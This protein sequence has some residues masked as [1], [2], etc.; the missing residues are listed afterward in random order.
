MDGGS[1]RAIEQALEMPAGEIERTAAAI[2]EVGLGVVIQ[3]LYLRL[4]PALG[5]TLAGG[6]SKD[7]MV[8]AK[9]RWATAMTAEV[10]ELWARWFRDQKSAWELVCL[11]LRSML[12]CLNHLNRTRSPEQ[13]AQFAADLENLIFLLD[14]PDALVDVGQVRNS[15][16]AKLSWGSERYRLEV[17]AID[18]LL[19]RGLF[20]DAETAARMALRRASKVGESADP[21][22]GSHM[23]LLKFVLGRS[24][25]LNGKPWAALQHF[26]TTHRFYQARQD[27]SDLYGANASSARIGA[28]LMAAGHIDA[29]IKRASEV[30]ALAEAQKDRRMQAVASG[31]LAAAFAGQK[32]WDAALE[33]YQHSRAIFREIGDQNSLARISHC[34]GLVQKNRGNYQGAEDALTESYRLKRRTDIFGLACVCTDL[35]S[36]FELQGR[37][38]AAKLFKEKAHAMISEFRGE[39]HS[40]SC[41]DPALDI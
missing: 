5:P 41:P 22:A 16:I 39:E 38:K 19:D 20:D 40:F 28:C 30:R 36:V 8:L 11:Q 3:P 2:A 6:L 17:L 26:A 27:H 7:E 14:N 18:R 23:A 32:K 12:V 1:F 13:V 15:L 25:L 4:D 10:S 33:E 9:R 29:A 24:L 31:Y 35:G 34:V 21:E 37:S